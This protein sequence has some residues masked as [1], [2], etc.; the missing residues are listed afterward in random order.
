MDSLYVDKI[1]MEALWVRQVCRIPLLSPSC[2]A[3]P[4]R[5]P[6]PGSSMAALRTRRLSVKVHSKSLSRHAL[7]GGS[8]LIM[9]AVFRVR[10]K[11]HDRGL[12]LRGRTRCGAVECTL[13]RCA[14]LS[15]YGL[16]LGDRFAP[17]P[18][19]SKFC[20]SGERKSCDCMMDLHYPWSRNYA[21]NKLL[22]GVAYC[23]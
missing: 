22:K 9:Q 7:H 4:C 20:Q 11:S 2:P 16:L 6:S 23:A 14:E 12:R 3:V 10:Q 8:V 13:S 18:R 17:E 15:V 1:S 5:S 19:P 21:L